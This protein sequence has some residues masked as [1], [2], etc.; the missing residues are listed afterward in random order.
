[1][2][3]ALEGKSSRMRDVDGLEIYGRR[4]FWGNLDIPHTSGQRVNLRDNQCIRIDVHR[5]R[6]G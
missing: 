3:E 2:G 5:L 4:A 6:T 1:M